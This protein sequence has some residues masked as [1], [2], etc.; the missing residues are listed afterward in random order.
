MF[1]FIIEQHFA[2]LYLYVKIKITDIIRVL[3]FKFS[4][5]QIVGRNHANGLFVYQLLNY[6]S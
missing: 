1:N 4:Y 3:F 6:G 5:L 2:I